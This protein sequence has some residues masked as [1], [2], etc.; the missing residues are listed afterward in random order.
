MVTKKSCNLS[1]LQVDYLE[2]KKIEPGEP[3]Q[4]NLYQSNTYTK[5]LSWLHFNNEPRIQQ[6]QQVKDQQSCIS[7][8]VAYL[9]IPS[10]S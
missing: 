10:S 9:T 2:N 3:V 8:F 4:M 6:R 1:E 5:Y 7:I